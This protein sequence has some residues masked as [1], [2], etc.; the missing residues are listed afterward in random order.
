ML[1]VLGITLCGF[2]NKF[3]GFRICSSRFSVP[4]YTVLAFHF[5]PFMLCH[6]PAP[7]FTTCRKNQESKNVS[8]QDGG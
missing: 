6:F 3:F 1:L 4:G 5:V 8:I 2:R 7:G